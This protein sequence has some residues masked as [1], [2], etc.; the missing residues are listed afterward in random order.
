MCCLNSFSRC[1]IF[2]LKSFAAHGAKNQTTLRPQPSCVTI[3]H[4]CHFK[5]CFY[6]VSSANSPGLASCTTI[7]SGYLWAVFLNMVVD[8]YTR[9]FIPFVVILASS[10][11]RDLFPC[12]VG[13]GPSP[14]GK[15]LFIA[16]LCYSL[17]LYRR[18]HPGTCCWL[19][20]WEPSSL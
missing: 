17:P 19:S 1:L 12:A 3:C 4:I 8:A 10:S 2:G 9:K 20:F 5:I 18:I 13:P 16:P 15:L 14:E 7:P 11:P 6:T